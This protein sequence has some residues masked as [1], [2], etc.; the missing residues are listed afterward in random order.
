MSL[1]E[2]IEFWKN[3]GNKRSLGLLERQAGISKAN[4][5]RIAS[6]KRKPR[7]STAMIIL[8]VICSTRQEAEG[9]L[10]NDYPGYVSL[11]F[12]V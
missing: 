10:A 12:S 9:V 7:L 3:S 11:P 4:L 6:G 5:S 8:S 2:K 1:V